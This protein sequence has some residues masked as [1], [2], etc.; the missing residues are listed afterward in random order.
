MNYNIARIGLCLLL[1]GIGIGDG[2]SQS[3]PLKAR[4]HVNFGSGLQTVSVG[5]GVIRAYAE[6]H[7]AFP[8]SNID[9]TQLSSGDFPEIE[10][11]TLEY[12]GSDTL[13]LN[14]PQQL[15]LLRFVHPTALKAGGKGY[16]CALLSGKIFILPEKD[17]VLGAL[18][19]SKSGEVVVLKPI[20]NQ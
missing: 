3:N 14:S 15:I 11:G 2:C 9:L 20:G 6:K 5:I 18:C 19:N 4:G 12:G 16:Y 8:A 17:A 13:T 1:I 7:G 10:W